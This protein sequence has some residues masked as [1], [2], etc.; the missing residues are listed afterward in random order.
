MTRS[1]I[2]AVPGERQFLVRGPMGFWLKRAGFSGMW[3]A[4]EKGWWVRV[5]HL[6][7]LLARADV[8]GLAHDFREHRAP[9]PRGG[10]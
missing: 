2:Y 9:R 5:E 4:I 1:Y 6:G 7:D 3:S 10:R 8:E